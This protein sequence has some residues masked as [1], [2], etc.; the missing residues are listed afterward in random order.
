LGSGAPRTT[1]GAILRQRA[2]HPKAAA[3]G[4]KRTRAGGASRLSP[5]AGCSGVD[6]QT[7]TWRV[8]DGQ[9]T[10]Y[11]V[12]LLIERRGQ[13]PGP[14]Y[15]HFVHSRA[16]EIND[17]LALV[18][19]LAA[20][21]DLRDEPAPDDRDRA[22][23][24][25]HDH[26]RDRDEPVPPQPK[27]PL[28]DAAQPAHKRRAPNPAP[29]PGA[30]RK[31]R[32]PDKTHLR[33][34]ADP[35]ALVDELN[36]QTAGDEHQR[37]HFFLAGVIGRFDSRFMAERLCDVWARD[38]RGGGLRASWGDAIKTVCGVEMWVDIGIVFEG[39]F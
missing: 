37:T 2:P 10:H 34:C 14:S 27:R 7:T 30:T 17:Q 3:L 31:A 25:A 39:A 11:Y 32:T 21:L 29:S 13:S 1:A 28:A 8:N 15:R 35:L 23:A 18:Q 5:P 22:R 26:D 19:Q 38:S 16:L 12:A 36:E 9:E 4:N 24:H 33:V 6:Q 20:R